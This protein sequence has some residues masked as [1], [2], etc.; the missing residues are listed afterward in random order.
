M[1]LRCLKDWLYIGTEEKAFL[2]SIKRH[3]KNKAIKQSMSTLK[4]AD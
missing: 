2:V 1:G 4:K 3:Q